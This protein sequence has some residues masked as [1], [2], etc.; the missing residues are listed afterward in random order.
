MDRKIIVIIVAVLVV[1]A[2]VFGLA[3]NNKSDDSSQTGTQ[4]QTANQGTSSTNSSENSQAQTANTN[5]VTIENF[6]FSPSQIT[7]KKGTTVTWTNND[8]TAH[9]VTELDDKDGPKSGQLE[10]GDKYNFTFNTAGTFH[11]HCTIHTD[12]LGTVIVTE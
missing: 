12:M 7:V 4:S 9:T 10:Q 3:S 2:I 5:S 8:T 11:Y 1:G 6:A